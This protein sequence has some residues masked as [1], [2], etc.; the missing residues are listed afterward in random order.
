MRPSSREQHDFRSID[1]RRFPENTMFARCALY[2][3][4]VLDIDFDFARRRIQTIE[5]ALRMNAICA[6][7]RAL[8]GAPSMPLALQSI[9][10]HLMV[11][12]SIGVVIDQIMDHLECL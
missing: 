4:N 10:A 3:L 2:S 1:A 12:A 5:F 11:I 9:R 8:P 7:R 6:R